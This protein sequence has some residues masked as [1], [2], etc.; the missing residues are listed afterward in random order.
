MIEQLEQ[1]QT[2]QQLRVALENIIATRNPDYLPVL[3]RSLRCTDS[4]ICDLIVAGLVSFGEAAVP[5]LLEQLDDHDYAAR[6]Q[7]LRALVELAHPSSF[8]TFVRELGHFAPSVRRA[9]AKGLGL[10]G[11]PRAIPVLITTL[12]DPDW[13]LRYAVVH[14]LAPFRREARVQTAL[15][16]ATQ[17][18]ERAVRLKAEELLKPPREGVHLEAPTG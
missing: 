11:D 7:G 2:P 1:A 14:A 18:P 16:A 3:I 10:L 17:D 9:A 13:A 5:V 15:Q 8:A 6:Y 4:A 12:D